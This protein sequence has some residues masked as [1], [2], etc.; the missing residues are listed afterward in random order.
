M[1][2][3]SDGNVGVTLEDRLHR[4]K[5]SKNGGRESGKNGSVGKARRGIGT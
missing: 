3:E 5:K 1:E 2:S 4:F